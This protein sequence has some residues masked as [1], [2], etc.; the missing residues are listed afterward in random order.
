MN[1]DNEFDYDTAMRIAD[2]AEEF[3]D[4]IETEIEDYALIRIRRDFQ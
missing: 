1:T 3:A 2:I 4:L